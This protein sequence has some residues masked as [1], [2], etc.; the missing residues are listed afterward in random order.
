MLEHTSPRCSAATRQQHSSSELLPQGHDVHHGPQNLQ[1][2]HS[3]QLSHH[4]QHG[5]TRQG[6]PSEGIGG[7]L[8]APLHRCVRPGW[9]QDPTCPST[10]QR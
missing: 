3:P 8:R 6:I 5:D 9:H 4:E 2:N 7:A 10:P 1:R